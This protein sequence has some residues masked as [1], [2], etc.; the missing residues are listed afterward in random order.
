MKA[1][2]VVFDPAR[3]RDRA[4]YENPHQYAE[5]IHVV[6]VN[7][8]RVFENGAMTGSRPGAVLYGPAA[9]RRP[10]A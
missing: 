9:A 3:V 6:L 2:V 8:V 7:G 4:T 5:G 1:D 10:K